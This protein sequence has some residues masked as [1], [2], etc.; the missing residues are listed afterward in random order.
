MFLLNIKQNFYCVAEKDVQDLPTVDQKVVQDIA[1][2][3][4]QLARQLLL[5]ENK[6]KQ[7]VVVGNPDDNRDGNIDGYSD[8]N[9]DG[10]LDGN[11]DGILDGNLDG[12]RN[13]DLDGNLDGNA[14]GN[15]DGNLDDN[16]D[17]NLDDNLDGNLDGIRNDNLDGN[18][19]GNLDD[20]LDGNLDDNLDVNLDGNLDDILDGNLDNKLDDM[21][22]IRVLDGDQAD[23]DGLEDSATVNPLVRVLNPL[24]S[25][26]FKLMDTSFR[27]VSF[28]L[29]VSEMALD[30]ADPVLVEAGRAWKIV[31]TVITDPTFNMSGQILNMA[32][33]LKVASVGLDSLSKTLRKVKSIFNE[34]H[35]KAGPFILMAETI[36]GLANQL[37]LMADRIL[38]MAE[39]EH[40][41]ESFLSISSLKI[42]S[43]AL[44]KKAALILQTVEPLVHLKNSAI[45][46][47]DPL[48]VTMIMTTISTIQQFLDVIGPLM[49]MVDPLTR[50]ASPVVAGVLSIPGV[51]YATSPFVKMAEPLVKMVDPS[52][53]ADPVVSAAAYGI[54]I[55]EKLS[56]SGSYVSSKIFGV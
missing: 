54:A 49:K 44:L 15:L 22:I 43:I 3:E 34:D 42:L 46:S 38:Q 21:N 18:L 36:L 20:N 4:N 29:Q 37:F 51:R 32:F 17:G 19:D 31:D 27:L 35:E 28:T 16:L 13:D 8:D 56:S 10:I 6:Q 53:V 45:K 41:G 52:M 48:L 39:K 47:M 1:V 26:L 12:I 9:L 24:V 25:M 30:L 11:L 33:V 14:D 7:G 23:F 50:L 2:V 5:H 40:S 55:A